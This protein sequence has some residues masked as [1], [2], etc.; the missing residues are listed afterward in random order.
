[1]SEE[2]ALKNIEDDNE[3]LYKYPAKGGDQD[4]D[5]DEE[6]ITKRKQGNASTKKAA[7]DFDTTDKLT[8]K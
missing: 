3:T 1:M 4:Y 2:E 7:T 5:V 6:R 8:K